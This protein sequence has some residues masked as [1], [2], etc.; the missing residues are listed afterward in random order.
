MALLGLRSSYG[1][2]VCLRLLALVDL[3]ARARWA[4]PL[5][6]V[7]ATARNCIPRCCARRRARR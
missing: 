3:L 2:S 6:T 4:D 7:G 5:C 1:V